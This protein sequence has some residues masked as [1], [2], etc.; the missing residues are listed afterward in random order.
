VPAAAPRWWPLPALAAATL[1]LSLAAAG[2]GTLPGDVALARWLQR[3]P[4]P[5]GTIAEAAYVAGSARP[6]GAV[7][8]VLALG[9]AAVRRFAAAGLMLAAVVLRALSPP[10]KDLLD[11]PRP[12][13]DVLRVT[14]QAEGGGFPSGHAMGATLF[15]LALAYLLLRVVHAPAARRLVV[16]AALAVCLVAGFGRVHRGAHWPSDVLG[17]YLWGALLLATTVA[18]YHAL[19]KL[20]GRTAQ[21][22]GRKPPSPKRWERGPGG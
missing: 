5:A 12:A 8:L 18:A 10:L 14:E 16:G 22:R 1:A 21:P 7:G 19:H 11:S 13:R 17:G 4:D 15:A 20:T 6:M 9:L 2:D 3:A